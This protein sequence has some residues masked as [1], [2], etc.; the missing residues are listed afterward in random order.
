MHPRFSWKKHFVLLFTLVCVLI[1]AFAYALYQRYQEVHQSSNWVA[2]SYNV[3]RITR[4]VFS[5][6]QDM[7]IGQRGYLLTYNQS[8]LEPYLKADAILPQEIEKFEAQARTSSPQQQENFEAF[9]AAILQLRDILEQQNKYNLSNRPSKAQ[10]DAELAQSKEVMDRIRGIVDRIATEESRL[11]DL[12]TQQEN[13]AE[14]TF[15][16]TILIGA[17][18]TIAGLF[19]SNALIM[20]LTSRSQEAEA[21][22]RASEER[23]LLAIQGVNDGL[24]DYNVAEHRIF[25]S[26]R[27][28]EMLGYTEDEF[29][30][31]LEAF[32]ERLHPED[33]ERTWETA[34]QYFRRESPSYLNYFRLRHKDGSYRWIM[35]RAKGVWNERGEIVRLVGAHTDITEQK[36]REEH[37][38]Q[39]NKELE[40][41]TYIASHDL[42]APLVNLKGFAAELKLSSETITGLMQQHMNQLSEAERKSLR[43]ALEEDMPEALHFITSS[44]EKMD[45]LTTA[46]LDLS[47][48]GR[49]EH[50]IEEIDTKA[51]V[52]RCLNSLA[53][54]IS[55]KKITIKVGEL[56]FIHSDYLAMEQIFSN[57]LDNAVKYLRPDAPGIIDISGQRFYNETVFSIRDNGRGIA[58][59]DMHKIFDMF[60]RAGNTKDIRG[61]GM[62][63]AYVKATVQRLQGRIWV[64]ST[65]GEGTVFHFAIPHRSIKE[66]S[67]G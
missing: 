27:F 61:S 10:I 31:T 4:R 11:L 39:I 55:E 15:I 50:K 32:N 59:Y 42:R 52:E 62:G 3:L 20:R 25:Y 21:R 22:L 17:V 65:A 7:E 41:F 54:E 63:M 56:P 14:R 45:T 48:I 5:R 37:L 33:Y 12:R 34:Q 28:R 53:Y 36:M 58:P 44:V 40:S 64:E 43:Q 29:P 26:P 23:F 18:L 51:L 46:I 16:L 66:A 67:H 47:R 38:A 13:Q 35:A 2:N 24:F 9:K 49:R 6:M 8:Y 1:N 57:I 60:R 30:N 19:A